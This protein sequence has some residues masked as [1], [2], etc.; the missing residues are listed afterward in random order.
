M[1]LLFDDCKP[2]TY[3]DNIW[4][5]KK[6]YDRL[7]KMCSDKSIPHIIFHGADGSGKKT[8]MNIFLNMMYGNDV[9]R[10]QKVTYNVSSSGNKVKQEE[11]S[12]S[13]HHIIIEP[14][15]TN[16]D[17]Y[18]VHDIVKTY[19]QTNILNLEN[20]TSNKFKTIQI[21][22]L[23]KLT[24]TAQTA[25]RRMIEVNTHICRF[26]MWCDNL[27]NVIDPLKSRCICIR[28]ERPSYSELFAYLTYISVLKKI[29]INLQEMHDIVKYSE[30]NIKQSLIFL[31]YHMNG[32]K[33]DYMVTNYTEA[34]N[35]ITSLI[36]SKNID[37]IEDIRDI[38]FNI[39]ITNYDGVYIMRD[40]L[41]QI[42]NCTKLSEICKSYIII[43][44]AEIEYNMLCG[45]RE[46][47]H[48][49]AFVVSAMRIIHK[50]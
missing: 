32:Y 33:N 27:S 10:I 44:T 18:L 39:S 8:M 38:F 41:K 3:D 5:H 21:S 30:C 20:L 13:P 17:K 6:I 34:I 14:T 12:Q 37:K 9:K 50:Y 48:F 22:N 16:Y 26:I 1:P 40:V 46:I 36:I 15:N 11:I 24:H 19:A 49:D 47:V 4:F 29:N 7:N 2:C 28:L 45:R 23:D 31:E 25:L 35:K 42:I 43:K